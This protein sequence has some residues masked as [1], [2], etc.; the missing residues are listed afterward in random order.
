MEKDER[1]LSLPNEKD[2][3]RDL[4]TTNSDP[5]ANY[6]PM[7][8]DEFS[9]SRSIREYFNVIYKR[10]PIIVTLTVLT[11]AIVAFYMYRQPAVYE[12]EATMIIEP[13]KPSP[14]SK[15]SI[16]INFGNDANYYNTQLRLLESADLMHDVVVQSGYYREPNLL[17]GQN[18]GFF[19]TLN[20][21]VAGEDSDTGKPETLP[22]LTNADA[23]SADTTQVVLTPEEKNLADR[24]TA[25][26]SGGLEVLREENT[27]I[28]NISVNS[29]NPQIAATT[30]NQ[31]VKIFIDQDIRRETQ[32]AKQA[33]EELS[34]SINQLRETISGQELELLDLLG[35]SNLPL[36]VDGGGLRAT[37]LQTAYTNYQAAANERLQIEARYKTALQA[38]ASGKGVYIPDIL[39]SK[40]YQDIIS[41]QNQRRADLENR[42]RDLKQQISSAENEKAQLL[43]KYTPEYFLVQQKEKQIEELKNSI[44]K[45][46]KEVK[47]TI[48]KDEKKINAEAV[49]GALASL[50]SQLDTVQGREA[51]LY[52]LYKAEEARA[53]ID[54]RAETRLTTLKR[55]IET[56]RSLLDVYIQ[57]QKEQELAITSSRPD[58]VKMS[59]EAQVPVVP[60]GP[61][62]NRNIFIAFLISLL[63]GI[64]LG[65]LLDYLDDSVR[66]SDDVGRHLGLPTLAMIPYQSGLERNKRRL[67]PG[68]NGNG[69]T[70]SS[71]MITLEDNRSAMAEAFRHLRTSLLFSNAGRP[72]KTILITSSQ[73]AEG[74]T[75]T[76]INT[77]ITLAQAGA[78]VVLIDCDLRRP[79]LHS[80]FDLENT[81]GLT[82]YLSGDRKTE[83][84]LKSYA[85][86]PKLKIITSGPIPPNPTELL[87]S[88]E[89][90][91]LLQFLKG[92]YKHIVIDSPPAISFT[93]A[94]I[95]ST[96]VDG[97]VLVAMVGKSSLHL[98][99]RFKQRLG[100]I[101]ARIYG[102]VLNGMKSNSI[103]YDY[104][105]YG[106]THKYYNVTDDDSTPRMEDM[107]NVEEWEDEILS[108]DQTKG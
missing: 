79:R 92:N 68:A 107:E 26:L 10:L 87:S 64:G 22:T 20:A 106:Y 103:G 38:N 30:A 85:A 43:V 17:G 41:Q 27:N 18:R 33:Y 11:T 100:T 72:P 24:Y 62:R 104:Y 4:E 96:L 5:P 108:I 80:H 37:T 8:D 74:K 71:A 94:A 32:G 61:Q 15:D 65:F 39:D 105:S 63:G 12:A 88:N 52:Q 29:T 28:V 98:M 60:I 6:Q 86:L 40:I 93:D 76:A 69:A 34:K 78:D 55:E 99:R 48:E 95:L 51:K 101:G 47:E 66:S 90:K 57:R 7:Y 84:L 67:L 21:I 83:N 91:N 49:S 89:M 53:N 73:P 70:T 82:N 44:L 25:V 46:E 9:E 2:Y 54:G 13:R 58:N 75:T 3:E 50:R 23:A 56:N 59:A 31:I 77:A 16:N 81:H 14:T 42:I 36:G 19:P 97:V 1:L 102:V 35:S 45:T